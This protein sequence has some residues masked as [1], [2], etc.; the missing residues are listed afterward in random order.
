MTLKVT[1][2]DV[3]IFKINAKLLTYSDG[4]IIIIH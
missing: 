2:K 3:K 4:H 1:F